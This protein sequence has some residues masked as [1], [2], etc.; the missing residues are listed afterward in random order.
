MDIQS[1]AFSLLRRSRT[2]LTRVFHSLLPLQQVDWQ[3]GSALQ[4]ESFAHLFSQVDGVVHTL[5]TLIEDT[6]YKRAVK[7][8]DLPGLFGAVFQGLRN[9]GGNPLQKR[10]APSENPK[11]YES[12]NR[13][14]GESHTRFLSV[15]FCLFR[16]IF[17]SSVVSYVLVLN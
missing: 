4:P 14:S 11:S 2:L 7:E 6:D 16:S 17:L 8:G 9:G 10:T 1:V 12:M 13:D 5:G 15:I 3:Q